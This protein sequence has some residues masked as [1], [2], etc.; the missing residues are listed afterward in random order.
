MVPTG[1]LSPLAKSLESVA[2][3]H[4]SVAVGAAQVAIAE[5]SPGSF[6][7]RMFAGTPEITGA[8][9]SITV[10]VNEPLDAF[11]SASVAV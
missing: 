5:Q 6:A 1:K 8:S 10:T 3:A 4:A 9:P 11:R 2:V 7:I